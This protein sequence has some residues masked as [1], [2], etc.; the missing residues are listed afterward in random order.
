MK[1]VKQSTDF[2]KFKKTGFTTMSEAI[3]CVRHFGLKNVRLR[4]KS[5][6]GSVEEWD[7]L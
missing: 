1:K 2:K 5:E 6:N 3:E 4:L 7:N